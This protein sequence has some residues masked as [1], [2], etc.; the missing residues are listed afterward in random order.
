MADMRL[1]TY[2]DKITDWLCVRTLS[3]MRI[4]PR[5]Y[6]PVYQQLADILREQIRSGALAPGA[7]LPGELEL[8]TTYGVG[9]QAVRQAL[10][11]L[12]SEAL[13]VTTRGEGTAVRVQPT[14]RTIALGPGERV[15][16]R[17]ATPAERVELELDEGVG[18]AVLETAD[19]VQLLPADEVQFTGR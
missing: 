10:G 14:R 2:H 11:V 7:A 5:S 19:G 15:H 6:V 13:V 3:H 16:Y 1:A 18:L 12:R 8:A 4:N 9:R 17:P